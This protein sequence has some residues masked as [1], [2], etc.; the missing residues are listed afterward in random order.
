MAQLLILANKMGGNQVL[1][2]TI[3]KVEVTE[4]LLNFDEVVI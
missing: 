3:A 4:K 2:C 1:F